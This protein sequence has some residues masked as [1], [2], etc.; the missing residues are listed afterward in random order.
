MVLAHLTLVWISPTRPVRLYGE[1]PLRIQDLLHGE[2]P[3]G[4]QDLLTEKNRLPFVSSLVDHGSCI[5]LC[6]ED[7]AYV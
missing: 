6:F 3:Q 7:L 1:D 2:D 4:Y 5:S